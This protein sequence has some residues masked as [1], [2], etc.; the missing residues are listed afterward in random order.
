MSKLQIT[1]FVA[2]MGGLIMGH[3]FI[4]FAVLNPSWVSILFSFIDLGLMAWGYHSFRWE[5]RELRVQAIRRKY[6]AKL[7]RFE[8]LQK[9]F[10]DELDQLLR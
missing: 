2:I 10:Y 4:A 6:L 7:G 8:D 9:E 3:G 5:I 1:H